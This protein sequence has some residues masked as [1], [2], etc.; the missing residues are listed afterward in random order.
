MAT[1]VI[2]PTIDTSA[3]VERRFFSIVRWCGLIAAAAA[4]FAA[5]IAAF[6]GGSKL[7]NHSDT[8]L[9][10]PTTTYDDF[11]R[12]AVPSSQNNKPANK[13][14]TLEDKEAEAARAAA[15]A[16]F[17]KQLKPYLDAIIASLGSY[18]TKV[19]QA[20]PSAQGI[21]D[22]VRQSMQQIGRYGSGEFAWKYVEGLSKAT[23]D[24]AADGDRVAKLDTT[25]PGRVRYD[26]FLDWYT[27][28]YIQQVRDELQRIEAEK[29]R[30]LA[31][32]AEAPMFFYAAAIAFGIFVLGT[33]LLVL[34]RIEFNT[35]TVA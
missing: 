26:A 31:S 3:R 32:L 9:R 35:R 10:A 4:L 1:G 6:G 17:E 19:G 15:D 29:V 18:A 25:D 27:K 11:R 20:K 33:I 24:L 8:T 14:T 30:A 23:R 5:V 28:S 12:T 16:E 13:D 22:Y 21:G 7:L 2:D 34:L